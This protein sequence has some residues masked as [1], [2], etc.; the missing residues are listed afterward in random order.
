M[1]TLPLLPLLV[2][3]T[4]PLAVDGRPIERPPAKE[5]ATRGGNVDGPGEGRSFP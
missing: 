4:A 5:P 3:L 1:A 2:A